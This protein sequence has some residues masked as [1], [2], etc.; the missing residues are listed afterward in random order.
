LVYIIWEGTRRPRL[1]VIREL[2]AAGVPTAEIARRLGVIYQ[3]VYVAIRHEPR[4]ASATPPRHAEPLPS[5]DAVLVGCVSQKNDTPMPA[6]DLYRSELFRRRRL[7]AEALGKPWWIVSAEYGLVDPNEPIA[8]Y[9][10]RIA[11]LSLEDRGRLAAQIAMKLERSLGTLANKM[12]ELHA[13]DDYYVQ[14]R[15][16]YE[17]EARRSLG[18]SRDFVLANNWAGMGITSAFVRRPDSPSLES[19]WSQCPP[20]SVTVE[21]SVAASRNSSWMGLWTCQ[22]GQI[23]RR[24]D[25][26]ACRKSAPRERSVRRVQPKLRS[27]SS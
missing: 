3:T 19:R 14:S 22:A 6:K 8:P 17:N 2:Y 24:P 26:T 4:A 13:G 11:N 15:P 16:L 18:H 27:D 20:F 5:P 23:T 9:D 25:G 12:L 7:W 21:V 10:T 1:E